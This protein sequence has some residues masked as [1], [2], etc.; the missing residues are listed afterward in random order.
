MQERVI[1]TSENL[2]L[3]F[4]KLWII[5]KRRWLPG[6]SV[7]SLMLGLTVIA[8]CLQK[9][10]YEAKGKLLIKKSDQTSALT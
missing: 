7:L 3:D 5:L 1:E 9:P 2:D 10:V 4:S 8:V 6:T